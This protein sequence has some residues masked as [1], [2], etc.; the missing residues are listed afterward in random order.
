M[1]SQQAYDWAALTDF[2]IVHKIELSAAQRLL[3][4]KF[5][6]DLI[7]YNAKVNLTADAEPALLLTRHVADALFAVK[8]LR[9]TLSASAPTI[10][11][12]GSGGGLI[13]LPLKVVWPEAQVTL[14]EP[15]RRK[16]DFLNFAAVRLGL[17]GLRVM[18]ERGE[19]FH[20]KIA[21]AGFDAIIARALAPLPEALIIGFQLLSPEGYFAVYQSDMP[22]PQSPELSKV[23]AL[24][25]ARLVK[26]WPYRLPG[27]DRDRYFV[28][29]APNVAAS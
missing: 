29:F 19:T 21:G 10:L 4:E 24:H 13:G 15:S 9:E 22:D 23:L 8:C 2:L 27:E 28:M 3:I 6:N 14:M 1:N 26:S 12:L 11:D 18:R 16:Y 20:Q 5:L 25:S 7:D 17:K